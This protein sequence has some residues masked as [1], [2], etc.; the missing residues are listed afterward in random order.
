MV[1][2]PFADWRRLCCL[3]PSVGLV[4]RAELEAFWSTRRFS[5]ETRRPGSP[6]KEL[7]SP[8]SRWVHFINLSSLQRTHESGLTKSGLTKEGSQKWIHQSGLSRSFLPREGEPK[9][10]VLTFLRVWQPKVATFDARVCACS[11]PSAGIVMQESGVSLCGVCWWHKIDAIFS[12]AQLK[13][14]LRCAYFPKEKNERR[15]FY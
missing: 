12:T 5:R 11:H 9:S 2:L 15:F 10:R 8:K 6:C 3:L 14:T 4:F 1:V 13:R 7:G